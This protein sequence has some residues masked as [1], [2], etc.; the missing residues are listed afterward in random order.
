MN[1]FWHVHTSQEASETSSLAFRVGSEDWRVGPKRQSD[2]VEPW[3]AGGGNLPFSPCVS[4]RCVRGGKMW[5]GRGYRSQSE[6][7]VRRERRWYESA[8]SSLSLSRSHLHRQAVYIYRSISRLTWIY[9]P[10]AAHRTVLVTG[11]PH[12]TP[13]LS[14]R[15][16]RWSRSWAWKLVSPT[17]RY[18]RPQMLKLLAIAHA[19][20]A[21]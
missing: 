2:E 16:A 6:G 7:E 17:A 11:P 18:V 20:K 1:L 5:G 12:P 13:P 14:A 3:R 10:G 9:G 8:L 4:V 15:R 19:H 21:I